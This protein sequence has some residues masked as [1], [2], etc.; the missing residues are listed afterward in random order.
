[1]KDF[2]HLYEGTTST[3]EKMHLEYQK[4]LADNPGLEERL[5]SLPGR[6]FSGKQHP[7]PDSRAVFFLLRSSSAG[8]AR[9]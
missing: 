8:R 6:V 3:T 9:P 5:N 4:L 2:N 1:M 7:N